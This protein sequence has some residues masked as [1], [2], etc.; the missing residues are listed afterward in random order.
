MKRFCISLF[1][2]LGVVV[3]EYAWGQVRVVVAIVEKDQLVIPS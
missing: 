2:L 1:L 3:N